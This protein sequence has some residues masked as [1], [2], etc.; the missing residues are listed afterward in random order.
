MYSL[1]TIE[2]RS[3]SR[4][5]SVNSAGDVVGWADR[6]AVGSGLPIAFLFRR[7]AMQ[8]LNT[9]IPAGSGWHLLYAASINDAGQILCDGIRRGDG[10]RR[11]CLL[12]P[13]PKA[14]GELS[15]SEIQARRV[16]LTWKDRSDN[17]SGFA[18]LRR[19]GSGPYARIAVVGPNT[20]TYTDNSVS[21]KTGYT[22][23]MRALKSDIASPWSNEVSATTPD[24]P[25]L[26]AP[27]LTAAATAWDSIQV[28]WLDNSSH[29]TGFAL[30]RREGI[31]AYVRIAVL[32]PNTTSYVDMAV[33]PNVHYTYIIRALNG[34][35][36]TPWS[37]EAVVTIPATPPLTP[38]P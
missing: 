13:I 28:R 15:V 5:A 32:A 19:L 33:A 30:L 10:A 6:A 34:D 11:L 31:G 26:A 24:N 9:L 20:T 22:Y 18:I 23:I 38:S 36:L 29:E 17:E 3:D 1:G 25:P 35:A 8:N 4:G 16:T 2:G 27:T 14:P 7:G 37:N 12:T 21:P